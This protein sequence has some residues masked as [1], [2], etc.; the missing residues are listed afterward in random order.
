[1]QPQLNASNFQA[2]GNFA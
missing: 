2:V 1:M